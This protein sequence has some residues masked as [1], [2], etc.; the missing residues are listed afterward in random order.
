VEGLMK[1]LIDIQDDLMN[2]LLKEAR[3]KVKKEAVILAIKSFLELKRRERL[4]A[5]IGN[6]EF[7]YSLEELE[8]MRKDG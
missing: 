5:L 6:Y 7:G 8:E 2:E 1:T 4:A 3:T